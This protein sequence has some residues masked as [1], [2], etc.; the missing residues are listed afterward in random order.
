M[1]VLAALGVAGV[2]ISGAGRSPGVGTADVAPAA[3]VTP[4]SATGAGDLD[5]SM[6]MRADLVQVS[7]S[8][9][10]LAAPVPAPAPATILTAAPDTPTGFGVV[11][12]T[13]RASTTPSVAAASS[14]APVAGLDPTTY[15]AADAAIGLRSNAQAVYSAVRSALGI[16]NIGGY[17]PGDPGD[18]GSGRAVDIMITS[19]AQGDAV[20]A[21]VM[22]HATQLHVNY[23]IWR[24]RIWHPGGSWRLMA[25]R[26]SI[27]ANHYDHVHVSVF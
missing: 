17:R 13:V 11:G 14:P 12:F 7:R 23:V 4:Q 21:Y 5:A 1:A 22:A 18:H 10:R 3:R 24:Q 27:T 25:D 6:A 20:A 15:A 16:T 2:G 19:Q 9:A 26:G 8:L